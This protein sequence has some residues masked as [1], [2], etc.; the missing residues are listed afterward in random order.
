MDVALVSPSGKLKFPNLIQGFGD[1]VN[2]Q[3]QIFYSI[4]LLQR[5]SNQSICS[6]RVNSKEYKQFF[7][8]FF[9]FR[10][11]TGSDVSSEIS[12]SSQVMD[13]SK[14]LAQDNDFPAF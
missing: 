9:F 2:T 7:Y 8:L 11:S 14:F 10:L 6:L 13:I 5:R 3:Q 4:H 12:D 1:I